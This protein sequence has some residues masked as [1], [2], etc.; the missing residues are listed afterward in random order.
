MSINQIKQSEGAT[1]GDQQ[2]RWQIH[3]PNSSRKAV[4]RQ[5]EIDDIALFQENS[6]NFVTHQLFNFRAKRKIE[7]EQAKIRAEQAREK[8]LS[9]F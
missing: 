3:H 6:K 1:A 7:K 2:P 9:V 8:E 4:P 5:E